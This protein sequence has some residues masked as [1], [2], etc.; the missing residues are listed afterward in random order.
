LKEDLNKLEA[1]LRTQVSTS[2]G[3]QKLVSQKVTN[4]IISSRATLYVLDQNNKARPMKFSEKNSLVNTIEKY[5]KFSN[6][7]IQALLT[8]SSMSKKLINAETKSEISKTLGVKKGNRYI[9]DESKLTPEILSQLG[10]KINNNITK[11]SE[12][13]KIIEDSLQ[14]LKN[15]SKKKI[16]SEKNNEIISDLQPALAQL[17]QEY[18]KINHDSIIKELSKELYNNKTFFTYFSSEFNISKK[19][20][21]TLVNN[22]LKQ[23]LAKSDQFATEKVTNQFASE[24]LTNTEISSRLNKFASAN[25]LEANYTGKNIPSNADIAQIRKINPVQFDQFIRTKTKQES[26]Q[27]ITN[28]T[29]KYEKDSLE[30]ANL[31]QQNEAKSQQENKHNKA[32]ISKKP[33]SSEHKTAIKMIIVGTL[34]TYKNK[35][36]IKISQDVTKEIV[37]ALEP[38]LKNLDLKTIQNNALE[39]SDIISKR[40]ETNKLEKSQASSDF[41]ISAN[42]L[43][44]IANGLLQEINQKNSTK[45]KSSLRNTPNQWRDTIKLKKITAE[46]IKSHSNTE[47]NS[48]GGR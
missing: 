19:S 25:N 12:N 1:H 48:R 15:N 14:L 32:L 34:E 41:T 37:K 40:L 29:P 45:S 23:H 9:L 7:A 35:N 17:D 20:R 46:K 36:G 39:I 33:I 3:I 2:E 4:N 11:T 5:F 38:E 30:A 47:K 42:N 28:K 26:Q 44:K 10:E 16:T 8:G 13:V 6:L 31:T 22:I 27:T 24:L 21:N 43:S 18:L